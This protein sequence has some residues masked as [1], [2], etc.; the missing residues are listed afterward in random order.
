MGLEQRLSGRRKYREES[1]MNK[2]YLASSSPRRKKILRKLNISFK[3]IVPHYKERHL[4]G[5]SPAQLVKAHAVG[6]AASS[7][8]KIREGIIISADTIVYFQRRVIG[9]PGN[10][11][12]AFKILESLQSRWHEVYTGVALFKIKSG[13]VV[14]KIIFFEKTG[15]LLKKMTRPDIERYFKKI[16]PLDK[17]GAYAIQSKQSKIIK[18][19]K[20]SFSNVAGFPKEKFIKAL[21][22]L[23]DPR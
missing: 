1:C 22:D 19:I 20:G 15:V 21:G 16:N 9:K 23:M 3:V 7:V 6:K 8:K 11:R 12:E 14:K 17:A 13:S 4:S 5:L 18:K 2:I 10:I